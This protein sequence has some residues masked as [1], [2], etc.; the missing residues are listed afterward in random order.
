MNV[1]FPTGGAHPLPNVR[2]KAL[3]NKILFDFGKRLESGFEKLGCFFFFSDLCE[4]FGDAFVTLLFS[5][6][7]GMCL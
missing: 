3:D 4:V 5:T 1:I 6:L 2:K 7:D